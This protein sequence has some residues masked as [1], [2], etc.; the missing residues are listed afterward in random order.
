MVNLFIIMTHPRNFCN[1]LLR[2]FWISLPI[3]QANL[4]LNININTSIY[5]SYLWLEQFD[6]MYSFAKEDMIWRI[7]RENFDLAVRIHVITQKNLELIVVHV[8]YNEVSTYDQSGSKG[9]RV[10]TQGDPLSPII[11]NVVVDAVVRHWLTIAVKEAE[12]RG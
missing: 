12:R 11:F 1:L 6:E 3:I 7:L 8:I 9:G 10:V 5:T 2:F 4:F